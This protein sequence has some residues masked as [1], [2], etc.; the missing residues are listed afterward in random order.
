MN[1]KNNVIVAKES[2]LIPLLL[3]QGKKE[4]TA[5]KIPVNEKE[6]IDPFDVV[7]DFRPTGEPWE[8]NFYPSC[9]F[10]L[11]GFNFSHF[12]KYWSILSE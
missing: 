11:I 2:S 10:N 9:N 3:S 5:V 6:E 12:R 7:D 4:E 1:N 8:G